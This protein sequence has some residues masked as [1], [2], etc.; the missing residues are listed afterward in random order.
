MQ[1]LYQMFW[2]FL[3]LC[4]LCSNCTVWPVHESNALLIAASVGVADLPLFWCSFGMPQYIS[5]Y[6]IPSAGSAV[7]G[8]LSFAGVTVNALPS[9]LNLSG[10]PTYNLQDGKGPRADLCC[11]PGLDCLPS[12][13]TPGWY[14][15]GTAPCLTVPRLLYLC[16]RTAHQP[17]G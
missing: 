11:T 5:G 7:P 9:G 15:A 12:D 17:T 14:L 6:E 8:Y 13:P 1:G 4:A 16:Q 2:L 3:I 10:I